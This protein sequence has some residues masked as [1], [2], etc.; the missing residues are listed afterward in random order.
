[1][2][3]P[4]PRS[5]G[6]AE[7]TCRIEVHLSSDDLQR[8]WSWSPG[9]GDDGFAFRDAS[10]STSP[11]S[12]GWTLY[13]QRAGEVDPS[14]EPCVALETADLLFGDNFEAGDSSRW[15]LLPPRRRRFSRRERA[16]QRTMNP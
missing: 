4:R 13:H 14:P 11:G 2:Q 12:T 6:A 15:G 5:Q 8:S 9:N 1:V 3:Q 16:T 10:D 7:G